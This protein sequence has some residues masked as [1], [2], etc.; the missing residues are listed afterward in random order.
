MTIT[1]SEMVRSIQIMQMMRID[2]LQILRS[3]VDSWH[4]K[5][6][7]YP[8]N[9]AAA[10]ADSLRG[11][12]ERLLAFPRPDP[13]YHR[14]IIRAGFLRRFR[15]RRLEGGHGHIRAIEYRAV[16][17]ICL[18][19]YRPGGNGQEGTEGVRPQ[20]H[21]HTHRWLLYPAAD[22]YRYAAYAIIHRSDMGSRT[23]RN[24][25]DA[26]LL[27]AF[28]SVAYRAICIDGLV[29][30]PDLERG[31]LLHSTTALPLH[32]LRR[33]NLHSRHHLLQYKENTA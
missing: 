20:R 28:L 9:A 18:L 13:L 21:L 14:I 31:H 25:H 15:P 22:V 26:T 30:R 8:Y 2:F 33:D 4:G 32:A 10:Y 19:S 27:G 16:C 17:R 6:D 3:V 24:T 5:L 29:R 12:G 1:C 7:R 11:E 23:D